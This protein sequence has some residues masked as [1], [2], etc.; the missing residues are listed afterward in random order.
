MG[1]QVEAQVADWARRIPVEQIPAMLAPL[2]AR[3]LSQAPRDREDDRSSAA[4]SENLLTAGELAARLG[5]RESWVRSAERD[6]RIPGLRAGK[7]VR[8]K[9]SDVERALGELAR[10]AA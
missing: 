2:S 3:L 9:L 5:L 6:G 1:K 8:F 4:G 10:S 7:Y